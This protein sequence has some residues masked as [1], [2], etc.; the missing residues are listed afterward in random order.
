[1]KIIKILGTA[2]LKYLAWYGKKN[3]SFWA[4][5]A[6]VELLLVANK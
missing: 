1:L 5:E 3:N 4:Y 2:K 6:F